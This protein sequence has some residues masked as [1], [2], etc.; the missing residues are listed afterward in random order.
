[1]AAIPGSVRMGGFIAPSDDTDSYATQDEFWNRGGYR[2]VAD[3]AARLAIT[4]DRR[5]LGMLVKQIDTGAFWTLTGGILDAN[6]AVQPMGGGGTYTNATPVQVA[7]G[8]VGVGDTFA[9]T[10]VSDMFDAI[11]YPYIAPTFT[12]LMVDARDPSVLLEVG[13]AIPA[14]PTFSW[15]FTGAAADFV[16]SSFDSIESLDTPLVYTFADKTVA[17]G[18]EAATNGAAVKFLAPGAHRF[19]ISGTDMN[20]DG[21]EAVDLTVSYQWEWSV[22]ADNSVA[23]SVTGAQMILFSVFNEPATDAAR[24]YSFPATSPGEYKYI[25]V[26][27]SQAQPTSFKDDATGLNIPFEAPV[28]ESAVT[29]SNGEDEDYKVYRSTNQMAAA[30][31]IVVTV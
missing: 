25:C 10:P 30:M 1:M 28:T 7:H 15:S 26:P 31:D 22:Y 29:N 9:A 19:K 3:T 11:L 2:S 4:A 12:A 20:P 16:S 6:W 17:D 23:T 18:T 24:T 21:G 14:T 5:K 27:A 13:E 8:G